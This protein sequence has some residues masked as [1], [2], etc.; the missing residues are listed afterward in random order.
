MKGLIQGIECGIDSITKNTQGK[1]KEDKNSPK[2][3]KEETRHQCDS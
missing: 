2:A 3:E 1:N